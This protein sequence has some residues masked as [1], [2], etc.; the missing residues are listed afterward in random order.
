LTRKLEWVKINGME[1]RTINARDQAHAYIRAKH[2]TQTDVGGQ[3]Y[4][5]HLEWVEAEGSRL[6][7]RLPPET[8]TPE[9]IDAIRAAFLLHDV[10]EDHEH[11]GVTQAMFEQE[12]FPDLTYAIVH[13]LTRHPGVPLTYLEKIERL[14]RPDTSLARLL[15]RMIGKLADNRHNSLPERIAQLPPERQGV[16]RRYGRSIAILERGIREAGFGMILD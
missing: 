16:V 8:L 11:T 6:L 12:G 4:C 13:D 2:A 9:E 1:T 14:T 15:G 5:I 10:V 3:P 7:E